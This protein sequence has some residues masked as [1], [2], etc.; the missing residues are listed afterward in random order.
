MDHLNSGAAVA[1]DVVPA[2]YIG[3][4]RIRDF[5]ADASIIADDVVRVG[6]G[7][8]AAVQQQVSV[9]YDDPSPGIAGDGDVAIRAKGSPLRGDAAARAVLDGEIENIHHRIQRDHPLSAAVGYA[10][11][12]NEDVGTV[13]H[14]NA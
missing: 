3:L 13:V 5:N 6:G 9:R 10:S 12:G 8:V 2:G 4:R 11:I 14:K 7:A 1:V